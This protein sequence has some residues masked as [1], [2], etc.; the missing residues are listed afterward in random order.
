MEETDGAYTISGWCIDTEGSRERVERIDAPLTSEQ[1]AEVETCL[2]ENWHQPPR[3][4]PEG[5]S[6]LDGTE[7]YLHITSQR[8]DEILTAEYNGE[9]EDALRTLLWELLTGTSEEYAPAEED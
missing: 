4:L 5:V 3:A 2:R 7:S 1:W 8:E 6:V 9:Y